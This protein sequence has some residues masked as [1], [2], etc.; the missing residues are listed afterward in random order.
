MNWNAAYLD[1]ETGEMVYHFI[2]D[3][4]PATKKKVTKITSS[5]PKKVLD[6]PKKEVA[7]DIINEII[8]NEHNKG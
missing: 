4:K 8:N 2:D 7:I 5:E 3:T 1:M 6:K